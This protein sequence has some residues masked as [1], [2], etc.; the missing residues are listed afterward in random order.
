MPPIVDYSDQAV[1]DID[2]IT[3]F[4]LA[5]LDAETATRLLTTLVDEIEHLAET[6]MWSNPIP[7]LSSQ[8][9]Q[10]N[11][12]KPSCKVYFERLDENAIRVLRVR[13]TKRKPL[14]PKQILGG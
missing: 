9:R 8:Y 5:I 13:G 6:P 12:V 2:E 7:G 10:W 4:Y 14:N 1:L 3:D 11:I